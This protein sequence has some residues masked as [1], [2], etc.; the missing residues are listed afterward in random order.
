MRL[1]R[2]RGQNAYM[3]LSLHTVCIHTVCIHMHTVS[4]SIIY[5]F[6]TKH[7]VYAYACTLKISSEI[8]Y[9]K[10]LLCIKY[11][12]LHTPVFHDKFR[13]VDPFLAHCVTF[14]VLYAKLNKTHYYL[15]KVLTTDSNKYVCNTQIISIKHSF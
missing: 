2:L 9:Y 6:L 12:S 14:L 10:Y 5:I 15:Y 7:Y 4:I 1:A 3:D 8:S 11:S 13:L